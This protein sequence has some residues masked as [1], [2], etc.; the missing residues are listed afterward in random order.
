MSN[1]KVIV[2]DRLQENFNWKMGQATAAPPLREIT[3]NWQGRGKVSSMRQHQDGEWYSVDT[4]ERD[5]GSI[6][7]YSEVITEAENNGLNPGLLEERQVY[8]DALE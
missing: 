8:R 3:L 6:D 1:K 5:D 7:K 4:W 2:V